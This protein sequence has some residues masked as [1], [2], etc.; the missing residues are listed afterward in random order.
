[1][2]GIKGDAPLLLHP[3]GETVIYA[4]GSS[5]IVRHLPSKKQSFLQGHD[6]GVSTLAIS[7]CGQFI[8]SGQ[9]THMGFPADVIVWDFASLQLKHRLSL[10][11]GAVQH[12]AFSPDAQYLATIGG[13]DDNA[14]VLWDLSPS[15]GGQALCG[16]SSS[17]ALC[18]VTFFRSSSRHLVTCGHGSAVKL[19]FI[20]LENRKLRP[21]DVNLG[22][23]K[24]VGTCV[25]TSADDKLVYVGT[26]TGDVLLVDC[27][28]ALFR[29]VTDA[30]FSGGVRTLVPLEG[31]DLLVGSGMGVLAR[32]RPSGAGLKVVKQAQ[33]LGGVTSTALYRDGSHAFVLSEKCNT[34]VL[35]VESMS[36]E[37]KNTGHT[38]PVNSV[39][40]PFGLSDVFM[41]TSEEEIRVWNA[42]TRQEILRISVP[43]VTCFT[44]LFSRDGR[45]IFSGWSDGKIR[46]F[47]PQSGRLC[48][49]VNDAHKGGVTAVAVAPAPSGG[50]GKYQIV[51]GGMEGEV[52]VWRVSSE[53]GGSQTLVANLK[54]HRGRVYAVKFKGDL[55]K[56]V[57][58]SADGSCIVWDL[59][60]F[61]RQLCLFEST[62]FKA[63][64]YHPDESQVI[65]AGSD[66]KITFWDVFDGQ[67]IRTLE[68]SESSEVNT[69]AIARH[70]P[71]IFV[72]AGGDALVKVWLYDEG[73]CKFVGKGHSGPV[74]HAKL[75]P[76][77][78]KL[79]SVGDDGGIFIWTLP[80]L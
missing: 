23:I 20:D 30:L 70:S 21:T 78:T 61:T 51:S 57:S 62:M 46:A 80:Q 8:A 24:R 56:C 60:T 42:K 13:R 40:F 31:G 69:L 55:S 45:L 66:R 58:A 12:L 54:E 59:K 50:E 63:V 34:Y 29:G 15:G 75:S 77:G 72:S 47:L 26:S 19:W 6:D 74:N 37:L 67:A 18:G 14:L 22:S 17:S 71:G 38:K 44:A 2:I 4:L 11:K 76:D 64:V 48:F 27:E 35:E 73:V 28:R 33:I 5:V 39:A 7:P 49:V 16:T 41:T 36:C 43:G 25:L 65:T 53:V 10:H 52:R 9:K 32:V 3:D 68:G 79:V 1:M